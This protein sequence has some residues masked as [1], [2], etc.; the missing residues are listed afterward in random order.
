MGYSRGYDKLLFVVGTH[1]LM[2]DKYQIVIQ[3]PTD[4]RGKGSYLD[5]RKTFHSP[6]LALEKL[7]RCQVAL[8]PIQEVAILEVLAAPHTAAAAPAP[9]PP[10][11]AT[12]STALPAAPAAQRLAA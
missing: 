10:A 8:T 1:T 11:S 7:D 6:K 2:Y 5:K 12:P 3:H 4:C 9:A